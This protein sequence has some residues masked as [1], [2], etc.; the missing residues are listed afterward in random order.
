M[1]VIV[2]SALPLLVTVTVCAAAL[3]PTKVDG[4]VRLPGRKLTADANTFAVPLK[5]SAWL[6]AL[7]VTL[8]LPLRLPPAVGLNVTVTT[9]LP[10]GAMAAAQVLVCVKSVAPAV[11]DTPVT[12]RFAL[13]ELL[14]LAVITELVPTLVET[15]D[16]LAGDTLNTGAGAAM[17]V[18]VKPTAW[19]L[20][21]ELSAMAIL[22]ARAPITPGLNVTV[23]VQEPLAAIAAPQVLVSA[24][25]ALFDVTVLTTNAELPELVM[26]TVCVALAPMLVEAKVRVAGDAPNTGAGAA[27]AVP[28]SATVCG[29]PVALSATEIAPER[30]PVAVGLNVTVI[31]QLPFAAT[32]AGQVLVCE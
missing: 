22:P 20:P 1:P 31:T 27:A 25:S 26:V 12:L 24:N 28:V 19:G 18:P 11:T 8:I 29:L 17:A 10:L 13:P 30:A 9:Q 5:A 32:D 2:R 15:N 23:M 16:K 6:P 4:K 21:A 14:M 3:S 7:S